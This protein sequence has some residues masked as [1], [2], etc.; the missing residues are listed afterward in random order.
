MSPEEKD[1]LIACGEAITELY[2]AFWYIDIP[3]RDHGVNF[4]KLGAVM[5]EIDLRLKELKE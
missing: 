2:N 3:R 5:S 1:L 4:E